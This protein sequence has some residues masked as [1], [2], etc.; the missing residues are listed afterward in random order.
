MCCNTACP[1]SVAPAPAA[2]PT[3]A[4]ALTV[5]DVVLNMIEVSLLKNSRPPPTPH[6]THH[7]PP[8]VSH[9]HC[10]LQRWQLRQQRHKYCHFVANFI[11]DH[12]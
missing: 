7:Q 11:S 5:R 10:V 6:S 3:S 9:H 1:Q 4:P 12:P 8:K 2:P